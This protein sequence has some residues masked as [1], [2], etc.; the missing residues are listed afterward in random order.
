MKNFLFL[1]LFS[2][3]LFASPIVLTQ[4]EKIFI[5][6][7]P[8]LRIQNER[9]W[10]PIDFRENAKAKGYAVDYITLLAEKAGFKVKFLPGH[11]WAT[12]LQCLMKKR[13]ILF[14]V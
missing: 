10:A 4:K 1:L 3:S 14:Q 5:T 2:L 6:K 13:L 12:Y 11:S 7:H 9:N 8:T